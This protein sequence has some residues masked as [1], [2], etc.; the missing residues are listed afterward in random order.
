MFPRNV[1]EPWEEMFEQLSMH[2]SIMAYILRAPGF[3]WGEKKNIARMQRT[4]GILK[5]QS[6][7]ERR[8]MARSTEM[9]LCR[10]EEKEE[11]IQ[12]HLG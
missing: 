5:H 10:E 11:R 4:C 6:K 12:R 7:A 3:L 2:L 8:D 1:T 9:E